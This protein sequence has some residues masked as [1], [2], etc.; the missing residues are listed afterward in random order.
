MRSL[1]FWLILFCIVWISNSFSQQV[2]RI[3]R[4]YVLLD[5]EN[6]AN[7]KLGDELLI[8]RIGDSE[9]SVTIAKVE[10]VRIV[11]NDCAVKILAES[12]TTPIQLG[13]RFMALGGASEKKGP[14]QPPERRPTTQMQY[15]P[16]RS[17]WLSYVAITAGLISG[18]LGYYFYY[19]AEQASK[20]IPVSYEH[21]AELA[22]RIR[23]YDNQSN[24]SC[25]LGG[26]LIAFGVIHYLFTHNRPVIQD[27]T[28]NIEPIQE[29]GY[30]GMRIQFALKLP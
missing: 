24:F 2:K 17:H 19:E 15:R 18:G 16:S 27:H 1:R 8:Y 11:G 23:R 12:Q 7:V 28:F 21:Q 20:E 22:D 10:V 4:P 6:Y 3:R 14:E 13:D 25:Y 26:G 29:K 9:E 30:Y 5:I